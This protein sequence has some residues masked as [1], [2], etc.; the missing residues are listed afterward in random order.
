[1]IHA[2]VTYREVA[3]VALCV[4]SNWAPLYVLLG[5]ISC[6]VAIALKVELVQTMASLGKSKEAVLELSCASL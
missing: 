5:P 1:M 2:V 4:H 6:S 3:S